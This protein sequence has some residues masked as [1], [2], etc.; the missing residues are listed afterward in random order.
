MEPTES[1]RNIGKPAIAL[2]L[3]AIAVL[4]SFFFRDILIPFIRMELNN[5]VQG[6]TMLLRNKGIQGFLAVSLIEAL[7]M[8]VVFIPAEFIQISSGLSYPFPVALLLCVTGVCLGASMIF[9]LVRVLH[10]TNSAY[11]KRQKRLDRVAL[12]AK[13]RNTV[14][15]LYLLFFMPIV[16]FGAICYYGSNTKLTYGKY[17]FTVCTGVIPSIVVS[18]LMG[19]AGTAFLV[20]SLPLW[21]LVLIILILASL[22]FL[23]V[24][25]FIKRMCFKGTEGTPD[26]FMYALA[27]AIVRLWHG[28]P[29]MVETEDSLLS[30]VKAPYVML[31]NHESFFDFYYI[32]LLEHPNNP[33]YMVNEF[34]CIRP[35]L[36]SIARGAGMIAKKL[37]TPDAPAVFSVMRTIRNGIPVVIFPESR[38]SP[39]GRSNPIMPGARLYKKLGV[40]LVLTRINGAYFANPKWRG[41]RFR[42]PVSVSVRKVITARELEAMTTQEIEDEVRNTL[43]ND[44]SQNVIARYTQKNKARNLENLIYRCPDCGELYST[45]SRGN[46]FYCAKC[47]SGRTL[48]ENYRFTTGETIAD[49]YDKVKELERKDMDRIDLS[50]RVKTVVFSRENGRARHENGQCR[51]TERSFE[52]SSPS[53]SFTKNLDDMP[54]LAFSCAKEF[55]LYHDGELM[56]FYPEDNPRQVARWALLVDLVAEKHTEE[57]K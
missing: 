17:I 21:L 46:T 53:V 10:V 25:I 30:Q 20:N 19:A 43:F 47:G 6:A 29:R 28:K 54:A 15:L 33:E 35:V 41:R 22:L 37:F 39:D 42:T 9:F 50:A 11:S 56:Y 32:S 3:L 8:V 44:A 16:P 23:L 27:F 55:E 34:Y 14:T 1:R 2:V 4:F 13:N 48:D 40:D 49:L 18:N 57:N 36:R 5:D 12:A 31:S 52:Y 51:L 24:G 38:L 45:K 7:Q 26:S